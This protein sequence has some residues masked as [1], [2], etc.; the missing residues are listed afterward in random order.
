MS[1]DPFFDYTRGCQLTCPNPWNGPAADVL[2]DCPQLPR[3]G[4][5][6]TPASI[7]KRVAEGIERN[8]KFKKTCKVSIYK[9]DREGEQRKEVDFDFA[10][11][12]TGVATLVWLHQILN[13]EAKYNVAA[14]K[15]RSATYY[16]GQLRIWYIAFHWFGWGERWQL[17]HITDNSMF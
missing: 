11:F 16:I 17:C 5:Y 12:K 1:Y 8:V 10:R 7:M 13:H 4:T 2:L 6:Q 3:P 9:C 14:N 15:R